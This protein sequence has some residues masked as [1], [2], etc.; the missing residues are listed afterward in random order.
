MSLSKTFTRAGTITR[1]IFF[2][3]LIQVPDTANGM[4]AE[5]FFRNCFPDVKKWSEK[6]YDQTDFLVPHLDHT[7]TYMTMLKNER[8]I[9][10]VFNGISHPDCD[11]AIIKEG[12]GGLLNTSH[13]TWPGDTTPK[14]RTQRSIIE[15]HIRNHMKLNIRYSDRKVDLAYTASSKKEPFNFSLYHDKQ[16]LLYS[17][18]IILNKN[19]ES[20]G[21]LTDSKD[22]IWILTNENPK[23]Y[24]A[25]LSNLSIDWSH[26]NDKQKIVS[27]VERN[28]CADVVHHRFEFAIA[29]DNT[30]IL[31]PQPDPTLVPSC[32]NLGSLPNIFAIC[33]WS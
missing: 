29:G 21:V 9:R 15:K 4:L 6:N 30:V 28:T 27:I 25:G 18:Y 24:I 1:A 10:R 17:K 26:R 32:L 19:G 2:Q 12:S 11:D 31:R 7:H 33:G 3:Q 20:L 8:N 22:R 23:N 5:W 13:S 14:I 16:V